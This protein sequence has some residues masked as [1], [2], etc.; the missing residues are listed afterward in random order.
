MKVKE[1]CNTYAQIQ[2]PTSSPDILTPSPAI[3]D[4]QLIS[5]YNFTTQA[6][7][8]SRQASR[9]GS[10]AASVGSIHGSNEFGKTAPEMVVD[11]H[12]SPQ[13]VGGASLGRKHSSAAM[14]PLT[15][16]GP[17][18]QAQ[19]EPHTTGFMY[20]LSHALEDFDKDTADT[21][22]TDIDIKA[23]QFVGD[24]LWN[25]QITLAKIV[26]ERKDPQHIIYRNVVM[27]YN[28]AREGVEIA[29]LEPFAP[30][31]PPP[32]GPRPPPEPL[33]PPL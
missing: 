7:T 31:H 27:A 22:T 18:A 33:A 16:R 14:S 21:S 12:T 9:A 3:G 15:P 23:A 25:V 19:H 20:S 24:L 5:A 17:P 28:F 10:P 26:Q 13:Q 4:S 32:K 30:A 1:N 11:P 8:E 6:R 2:A 29:L